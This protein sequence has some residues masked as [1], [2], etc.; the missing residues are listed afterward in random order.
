MR[1]HEPGAIACQDFVHGEG[2]DDH[3]AAVTAQHLAAFLGRLT[4]QNAVEGHGRGPHGPDRPRGG[5]GRPHDAPARFVHM[6]HRRL[7]RAATERGIGGLEVPGDRVELV[8]QRLGLDHQP[9]ARHHADLA[10]ERQM[11][12]VLRDRHAD[13]EVGRIARPRHHLDRPGGRHDG[14]VAGTAVLLADVLLEL[15]RQLDRGDALRGFR[16]SRHLHQLAATRGAPALLRR[17]LMT[18]LDNR[19]RGLRA[20]PMARSR[21]TR[22]RGRRAAGRRVPV[23]RPRL[24]QGAQLGQRQLFRIGDATEPRELRRQLQRLGQEPLI[25]ALEE[26]TDLTQRVDVALLRQIDHVLSI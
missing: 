19:E 17:Q 2:I 3:R 11:I 4:R 5:R 25:L 13:A 10:F 26:E 18:D 20:R 1:E 24:F 21:R 6:D 16:L 7:E 15:I 23:L 8:P 12:K 14:P 9:F 22:R